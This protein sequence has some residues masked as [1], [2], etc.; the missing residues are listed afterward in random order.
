MPPSLIRLFA[1]EIKMN[2]A[3][4]EQQ[5]G[6]QWTATEEALKRTAEWYRARPRP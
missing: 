4:A 2:T 5:L 1:Q 3:L 6:L